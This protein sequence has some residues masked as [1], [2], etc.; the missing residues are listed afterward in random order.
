V[1][2]LVAIRTHEPIEAIVAK[3]SEGLGVS[4]TQH[5]SSQWGDPYFSGWPDSE[6][7]LTANL[8]PMFDEGDPPDERW[9]SSSAREAAYLVWDTPDPSGAATSLRAMGLDAEVVE[10]A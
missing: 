9:F 3:V 6:I 4:L 5:E 2:D 10:H 7:K 8:D 1:A